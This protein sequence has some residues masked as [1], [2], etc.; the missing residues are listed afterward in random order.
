LH[1]DRLALAHLHEC[2]M[3]YVKG[4]PIA[5]AFFVERR[6]GT[7]R[8]HSFVDDA[9]LVVAVDR[10]L[11]RQKGLGTAYNVASALK[12]VATG[13]KCSPAK[14]RAAWQKSGG[15]KGSKRRTLT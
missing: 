2:L 12:H 14:V 7:P 10:A 1:A 13:S 4:V 8:R 3:N 6:R 11:K 5:R 15:L 9:I